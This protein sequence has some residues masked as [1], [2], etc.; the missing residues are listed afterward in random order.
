ML[1]ASTLA[2]AT[3]RYFLTGVAIVGPT[4]PT[5]TATQNGVYTVVVTSAAGCASV[6]SAPLT[7][8]VTATKAPQAAFELTAYPNPTLDGHLTVTM[9]GAHSTARL[10]LFNALGMEV[11]TGTLPAAATSRELD[12]SGLAT[13]VYVLRATTPGGTVTQRIVR[14]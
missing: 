2:G 13:G 12:L 11:L 7:V 1:T 3:Y 9:P 14:Q 4:G 5:Y 6:A 10:T 8:T